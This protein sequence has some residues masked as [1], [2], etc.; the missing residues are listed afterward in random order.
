MA[1]FYGSHFEFGG[2]SSRRYGLVLV[3][4]KEERSTLM[5][6]KKSAIT[7][8]NKK[9]NKQ[10]IVGDDYGSSPI[11]LN[12]EIVTY[13]Q[14]PLNPSNRK[15]A[16]RWLFGYGGYRKM[17][18]DISDD[19][20]GDFIEH[21]DGKRY[22]SYLNC[23]LINPERIEGNGGVVGY[24][25]TLEADSDMLWQEPMVKKYAINNTSAS[26]YKQI[27]VDVDTDSTEYTYPKVTI[28]TG[29]SGDFYIT[30]NT[31]DGTR[32]TKFVS[33]PSGAT[34]VM[35]GE[36]NYVSNH[37]DK[38]QRRNFVRLLNG[39]NILTVNGAVSEITIEY[40]ARRML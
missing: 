34:I 23:R 20:F 9:S 35:N 37:Y 13:N 15:K 36:T 27:T 29:G 3:S 26:Q 25:V 30:N 24:K 16:E 21:I 11:T 2:E 39:K 17:F 18:F 5:C 28:K 6:G 1:D 22:R 7:V 12:L 10:Y 38:M 32:L 14:E 33:V 19:Y 40:S 8:F 31:D 4:I